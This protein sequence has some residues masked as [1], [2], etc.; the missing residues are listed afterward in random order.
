[1][2]GQSGLRGYVDRIVQ[3]AEQQAI[4]R[5]SSGRVDRPSTT[6]TRTSFV[7]SGS[8]YGYGGVGSLVSQSTRPVSGYQTISSGI[9]STLRGSSDNLTRQDT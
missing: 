4:E 9:R 8:N 2:I 6:I 5:P 7:A 3:N 1:M